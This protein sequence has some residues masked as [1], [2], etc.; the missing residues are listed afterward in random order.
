MNEPTTIA[1]ASRSTDQPLGA[2]FRASVQRAW[3][4][5]WRT[6]PVIFLLLLF[7]PGP[8][9]P[10]SFIGLVGGTVGWTA[11]LFAVLVVARVLRYSRP[12]ADRAFAWVGFA[13]TFF[14][15]AVL[16]VFFVQLLSEA[17]AWFEHMPELVE[18]YNARL[19]QGAAESE[20]AGLQETIR[21]RQAQ[22]D[23]EMRKELAAVDGMKLDSGQREAKKAA[24]VQLY[25]QKIGPRQRENVE[26]TAREKLIEYERN[27]R[28]DTSPQGLL[29]YFLTHGPSDRPQDSGVWPA[30]LGSLMVALITVL[31]AVPVG[32][33][34]ALYL[35]EY[36]Q[37]GRLNSLIQVNINNL[38]GVPS[39]VYGILGAFVFVELIFKPIEAAGADIAARNVLGGGLTLGLL[40]LPVI[41]VSAQEAI[42]AV[43][44][45]IRQGAYALGATRWQVI[46]TQ[47]LPL[48][49]PGILTGTIL[50]LSRAVGEAAPLV[51]FG[52]LLFVN[53][54]PGLFSR[55]TILPMQ[56][57]GWADL[58]AEMVGG[59]RVEIWRYNA[60]MASLLLLAVLLALNAVAIVLRSR[61]Q[62]KTKW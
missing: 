42:R 58:P 43:P 49:R 7:L 62:L 14:G 51:L 59:E 36:R 25:Q 19:K 16:V 11:L 10:V 22:V 30:L 3:P 41:I 26:R 6:A 24:I 2:L 50:S 9:T 13:A 55:F 47:V 17:K 56:I 40:T 61:A 15:L 18:R 35:E 12:L 46:W 52:A 5:T 57:F 32:V 60:A 20:G 54:D 38:A 45:S 8:D 48:A 4:I 31:F 39:V 1:E 44:V 53:E 29:W 33:A 28:A 37:Q 21:K 34:A 27:Y 23:A